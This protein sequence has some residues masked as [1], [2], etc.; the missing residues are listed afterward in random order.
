MYLEGRGRLTWEITPVLYTESEPKIMKNDRVRVDFGSS[1]GKSR[2][3]VAC[4]LTPKYG[5]CYV[6]R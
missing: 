1:P 2:P 4:L 3:Q 5:W 6:T